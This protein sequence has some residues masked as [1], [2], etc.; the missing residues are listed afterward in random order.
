MKQVLL[1]CCTIAAVT[2]LSTVS[3]AQSCTT[4]YYNMLDWMNLDTATAQHLTGNA[5]PQYDVLPNN[6]VFWHLKGNTG[7]QGYPWDVQYY[8]AN[9]IYSWITENVWSDPTTFKAQDSKTNKPWTPICVPQGSP[10]Q[11]LSSI[12]IP[13]ANTGYHFYNHGCVK[14]TQQHYLG[15][16]VNEIWNFGN[17]DI[18]G[19]IG[20]H[21][22]L[23]LSYRYTCDSAYNNCKY[24]EVYDFMQTYGLVRWTYY[25]LQ[26]NGTYQQQSQS[27]FNNVASGGAPQP[28]FPCGLPQ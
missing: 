18:G 23:E 21:P 10:G 5:N 11:K 3:M 8:D 9:Y 1:L 6:N 14:D 22:D 24:K 17:L 2:V 4:G 19:N 13:S 12:T 16:T 27:I 26:A 7:G 15:N 28:Y 20:S 25:I